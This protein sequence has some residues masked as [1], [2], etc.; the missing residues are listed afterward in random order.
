MAKGLQVIGWG[1]ALDLETMVALA[2]LC[3]SKT[4]L[5]VLY[6][7]YGSLNSAWGVR[8]RAHRSANIIKRQP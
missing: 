7:A 3:R 6:R 1:N 5:E 2:M 4:P 8:A